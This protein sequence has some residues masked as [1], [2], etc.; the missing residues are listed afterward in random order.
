[1]HLYFRWEKSDFLKATTGFKVFCR[2][3]KVQTP[4]NNKLI[5]I[6]LI[7]RL[8]HSARCT[9]I[10]IQPIFSCN[11]A[12]EGKKIH[13]QNLTCCMILRITLQAVSLVAKTTVQQY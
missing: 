2:P 4:G 10:K 3:S 9:S 13:Y 1:M 11:L 8:C 6:K 7:A 12:R 5:M